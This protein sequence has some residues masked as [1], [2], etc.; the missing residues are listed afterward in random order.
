MGPRDP[1]TDFFTEPVKPWEVIPSPKFFK[2]VIQRQWSQPGSIPAP[3]GMD[4]KVY[5][6]EQ[7]LEDLLQIPSVDA[8]LA[9]GIQCDIPPPFMASPVAS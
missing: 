6:A 1:L 2:D 9:T 7:E 3:S 5:T 8:P 4:R